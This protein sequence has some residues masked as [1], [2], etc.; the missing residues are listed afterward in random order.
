MYK[1]IQGTMARQGHYRRLDVPK[2]LG[3]IDTPL[4]ACMGKRGT[5]ALNL[6]REKIVRYLQ[7]EY[8]RKSIHDSAQ[9]LV[10]VRV[11]RFQV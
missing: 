1:R 6:I 8:V 4:D 2:E 11:C 5:D 7:S 10:D 3:N 9:L